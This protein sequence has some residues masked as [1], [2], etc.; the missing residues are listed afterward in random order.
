MLDRYLGIPMVM[1][2]GLLR[3]KRSLP[4][5]P[6]RIGLFN[7]AAIGDTVLMSAA[8]ADLRERYREA[9]LIFLAGPS[10]FEAARLIPGLDEV[11]E[12]EILKPFSAIRQIRC[13][14]LT[15]LLD[16]GPWPRLN[17]LIALFSRAQFIV[18][19]KTRGEYRHFAYDVAVEH[20]SLTHELINFRNLVAAADVKAAHLPS[21]SRYSQSHSECP[22]SGRPYIIFHL[23]PGGSGATFKEWPQTR[24]GA[25]A[26][27]LIND[28][29]WIVLSGSADQRKPN[30]QLISR[31]PWS[32]RPQLKNIAGIKLSELVHYLTGA[33][34]VVS[35]NTGIM[36]MADAL[37][38]PLVALHGPTSARRW[39]PV[40][41]TSV[42]V[43]SPLAG[44][45]Y[46]DLGF[47][48][49]KRPPDC[50]N[51]I[52]LETVHA[53]CR[54]VLNRPTAED[55]LVVRGNKAR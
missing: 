6:V 42:S 18:G 13:H 23:W 46:L 24:W 54:D 8:A 35:V 38:A 27:Q 37:K 36:H 4:I 11:V 19:F 5:S 15:I 45:G 40:N 16:F 25:L 21:L 22:I 9:K 48:Y 29:Y 33:A 14:K 32:L 1:A 3:K 43:E 47:E 30:D 49:P 10:N 7:S 53:A 2:A 50:M 44:C 31:L 55:G 52:S 39:G 26:E 17:A 12:L 34:L 28:G 41:K 20:S 51:A